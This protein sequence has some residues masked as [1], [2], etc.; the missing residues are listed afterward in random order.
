EITKFPK[1][2]QNLIGQG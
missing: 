1:D 2:Q